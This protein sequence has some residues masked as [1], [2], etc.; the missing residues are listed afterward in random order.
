MKILFCLFKL[1]IICL[2]IYGILF[3][4]LAN[5]QI[6][7]NDIKKNKIT[8]D[9]N[10]LPFEFFEKFKVLQVCGFDSI[11]CKL[12]GILAIR[13]I[14]NKEE[15]KEKGE[16]TYEE[17]I[18]RL[19]T[20]KLDS[21]YPAI[22]K[23]AIEGPPPIIEQDSN[24]KDEKPQII[25]YST[26]CDIPLL[27]DTFDSFNNLPQYFDYKQAL[28]CAQSKG[29]ILLV[30]FTGH[31]CAFSHKMENEV[32]I[33]PEIE[34]IITENFIIVSLY[35]DHRGSIGKANLALEEEFGSEAQPAYFGVDNKGRVINQ[36]VGLTDKETF[37]KFLQSL[38]NKGHTP[39]L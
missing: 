20:L 18:S 4:N 39:K 38:L 12:A 23:L 33:D 31:H 34:K 1:R 25:D 22:R 10:S 16:T 5:A 6:T 15:A 17:V 8:L 29:K 19:N 30:Y 13:I 21:T 14:L 36:H 27:K 32:L 3:I 2:L 28:R 11:D 35:V 37:H 7:C 24:S 26:L 9:Y